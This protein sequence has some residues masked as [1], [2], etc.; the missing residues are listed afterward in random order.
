MMTTT[1]TTTRAAHARARRAALGQD[2]R[3]HD[4]H[5]QGRRRRRA[6]H[7]L[8]LGRIPQH[9]P[10][11]HV[12]VRDAPR[13]GSMNA[14]V[15]AIHFRSLCLLVVVPARSLLWFCCIPTA[16]LHRSRAAVG[17][18]CVSLGGEPSTVL[19]HR[20]TSRA[21]RRCRRRR[22]LCARPTV[23]RDH[24]RARRRARCGR[25]RRRHGGRNRWVRANERLPPRH[26]GGRPQLPARRGRTR[27]D[28]GVSRTG[29]LDPPN[30]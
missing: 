24:R 4:V 12:Q 10:R 16:L 8:A 11:G 6:A 27:S 28:D 26:L 14:P 30:H 15:A 19:P 23:P 29:S 17:T 2:A 18:P 9:A 3:V 25:R 22:P 1:T 21:R 13:A 20:K 5:G 7:R